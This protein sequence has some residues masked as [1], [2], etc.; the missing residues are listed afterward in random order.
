MNLF[1]VPDCT[2]CGLCCA[3]GWV[4]DAYPYGVPSNM[5]EMGPDPTAP[6]EYIMRQTPEG[7]C[8]AF[9]GEPGHSCRCTVYEDRPKVCRE[10][11]PGC[12]LCLDILAEGYMDTDPA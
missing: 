5:M 12:V 9:K 4:V 11:K 10:F 2:S 6:A 7:H 1:G 8:V 3:A